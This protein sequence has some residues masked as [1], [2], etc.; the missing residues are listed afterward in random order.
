MQSVADLM[1]IELARLA[2]LYS[3]SISSTVIEQ[4]CKHFSLLL[5]WNKKISLTGITEPQ[6][7]ARQLYFEAFYAAQLILPGL[8]EAADIGSGGGFPGLPVSLL[9][10]EILFTLIE[11]DRRK[12]AFLSE[13]RR[14]LNLNNIQITNNRFENL[15]T[16]FSLVMVRA[17]ERFQAQMPRLFEFFSQSQQV[18]LFLTTSAIEDLKT[19]PQLQ[20]SL[21][22]WQLQTISLPESRERAVLSLLRKA[23][24]T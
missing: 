12:A 10:P 20:P 18:L 3:L 22:Y 14:N 16:H 6:A 5:K 11:A 4:T 15:T 9:H 2:Q 24:F 17:L 8:S 7:A 19:S 21:S 13:V 23:S 1:G